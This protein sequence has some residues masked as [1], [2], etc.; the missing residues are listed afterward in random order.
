MRQRPI[1]IR[2]AG[3]VTSVGLSAAAS[4]AAIRAKLTHPSPT[5]VTDSRGDWIVAHQVAFDTTCRG[6]DRLT[7]LAARVVE[8]CMIDE[9]RVQ[10][11]EIPLLLCVAEPQRPGRIEGLDDRLFVDLQQRLNASFAPESAVVA[12]GRVAAAV[13]LAQAHR[14]IHEHRHPQVVIAAVDS[15]IGW[16]TLSRYDRDERLLAPFNSNGFM[17]GEAAG[18]VL[19]SAASKMAQMQCWGVGFGM[20]PAHV[21]S[22]LPLRGD[23]LTSAIKEALR[24]AGREMHQINYRVTDLSGEQYYFKEAALALLHTLRQRTESF[25]LWHP[26]ECIGEVGAAAGIATLV[27]ATVASQKGYG[28]GPDVLAHW[29]NDEGQRAAAVLHW[30]AQA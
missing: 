16:A 7:H 11:A 25:D 4:S 15:L 28:P 3:L 17:P 24:Q 10:W 14:L 27:V 26:A 13:A 2:R 6:L 20:E 21:E 18:A 5:R 29:A 30:Q 22:G 12:H 1:A 9:P 23:G 19:V 8:E